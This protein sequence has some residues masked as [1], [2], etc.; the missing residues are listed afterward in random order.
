MRSQSTWVYARVEAKIPDLL[1]NLEQLDNVVA[2]V[3]VGVRRP[4]RLAQ[5]DELSTGAS[6]PLPRR[7]RI[8]LS[9]EDQEI[10]PTVRI[11]LNERGLLLRLELTSGSRGP[12]DLRGQYEPVYHVLNFLG[13]DVAMGTEEQDGLFGEHVPTTDE[14]YLRS[15][16]VVLLAS[17]A[18]KQ[19]N[20]Y[21]YASELIARSPSV[22]LAFAAGDG[23]ERFGLREDLLASFLTYLIRANVPVTSKKGDVR[24]RHLLED[25]AFLAP[26][27]VEAEQA[28]EEDELQ[29]DEDSEQPEK[30]ARNDVAESG[31]SA[32]IDATLPRARSRNTAPP[33]PL[34]RR[35]TKS[36]SA[37]ALSS[38]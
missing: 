36:C 25:A 8:P 20:R 9:A 7:I 1:Q 11:P 2:R 30:R 29:L 16:A 23:G 24:M 38:P 3:V 22:A 5:C 33:S 27:F 14:N 6:L 37:A 28:A 26:S 12:K 34:V 10:A 13:L 15:L 21:V 4:W 35:S 31:R 18:D 17:V 19:A 32:N